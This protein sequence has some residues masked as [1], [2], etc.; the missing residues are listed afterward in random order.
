MRIQAKYVQLFGDAVIPL[1][2]LF[3][4]NWSLYFIL[5]FYFLDILV[6]ELIVHLKARRIVQFQ[7]QKTAIKMWALYSFLSA[8]VLTIVF[9]MIHFAM[10]F[11]VPEIDF[12]QELVA[13]WN[14]E[15]MGIKQ[16]YVL[17]P[18]LLLVGVQQ[19]RMT[20]LM[21][22]KYRNLSL[23]N[24]WKDHIQALIFMLAFTGIVIG[25]SYFFELSEMIYVLGIVAVS[26]LYKL[27]FSE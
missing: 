19:Y 12:S 4:W 22:A 26:T 17:L 3:L 27:R 8:M 14:Y 6:N 15:E 7:Q 24:L 21:A 23:S 16:G 25:I 5:L 20:F 11:I 13:F 1:L 9:L 10:R 2:G 18:L